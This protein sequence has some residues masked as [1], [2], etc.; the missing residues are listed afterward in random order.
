MHGS[1]SVACT[2]AM[3]GH[4]AQPSNQMKSIRCSQLGKWACLATGELAQG[5]SLLPPCAFLCLL[6]QLQH[7]AAAAGH[8]VHPAAAPQLAAFT[9][10][11]AMD[12]LPIRGLR[13]VQ[14]QVPG[15]WKWASRSMVNKPAPLS[16]G[17]YR[18]SG[19]TQASSLQHP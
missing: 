1:G 19:A 6:F 15:R 17:S 3:P 9:V 11:G 2:A 18:C 4:L 5:T 14:R 10:Q 12:V 8:S 16:N 7:E 13:R